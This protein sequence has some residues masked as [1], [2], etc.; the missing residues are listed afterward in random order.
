MRGAQ[1]R[2]RVDRVPQRI[3]HAVERVLEPHV[4]ARV[5]RSE[6]QGLVVELRPGLGVAGEEDG[7][8]PIEEKAFDDVGPEPAAD[9]VGG[10]EEEEVDAGLGEFLRGAQTREAAADDDDVGLGLIA[11]VR[12]GGCRP[13]G[14]RGSAVGGGVA[15]AS[16][17]ALES[18]LGGAR[19]LRAERPDA[20]AL[21]LAVLDVRDGRGARDGCRPRESAVV[22]AR[23]FD[24]ASCPASG[25][26]ARG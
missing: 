11:R 18:L 1:R 4:R 12:R 5:E 24:V 10:F 9:G 13:R 6:V 16:P 22:D 21:D 19:H 26:S 17:R 2:D 25:R 14:G 15:E 23:E 7:E 8:A 3:R 20:A